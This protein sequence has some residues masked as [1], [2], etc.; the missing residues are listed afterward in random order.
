[1]K[2]KLIEVKQA[3]NLLITSIGILVLYWVY[4]QASGNLSSMETF[5]SPLATSMPGIADSEW[6]WMTLL[7][8][9]WCC[10]VPSPRPLRCT[11]FTQWMQPVPQ[12]TVKL[13]QD[14]EHKN[15]NNHDTKHVT[16]GVRNGWNQLVAACPYNPEGQT[17]PS[18]RPLQ[19][20]PSLLHDAL[21]CR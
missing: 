12:I 19:S 1:M 7:S 20:L 11:N 17:R 14:K 18:L 15:I 10:T 21:N 2:G 13:W 5:P 6:S 4:I 3:T 9:A 8:S 16:E